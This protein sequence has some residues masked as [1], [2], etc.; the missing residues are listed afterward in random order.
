MLLKM[1]SH[2]AGA[3]ICQS[4]I[5]RRSHRRQISLVDCRRLST[6]DSVAV[7]VDAGYDCRN[8]RVD[9]RL[10]FVTVAAARLSIG[11]V[12]CNCCHELPFECGVMLKPSIR[13]WLIQR[14][15]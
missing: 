7:L 5:G 3:D 13:K 10:V 12:A 9:W 11:N 4:V 1:D 15:R 6:G 14:V 2:S 8:S